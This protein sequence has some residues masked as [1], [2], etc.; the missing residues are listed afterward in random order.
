[1]TTFVCVQLDGATCVAWAQ[2]F[3]LPPLSIAEGGELGFK[4]LLVYATAWGCNLIVRMIIN[5]F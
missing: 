4:I 1:M 2:S 5:K 3:S